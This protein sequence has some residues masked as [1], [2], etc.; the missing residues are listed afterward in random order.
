MSLYEH[1]E[2][3]EI[4]KS[5]AEA[6]GFFG[7][8]LFFLYKFV[9]GYL[10]TNLSLSLHCG[11]QRQNDR[12]DDLVIR[13]KL[14]KGDRGA[15]SLHDAQ[16]RVTFDGTSNTYVFRGLK[17]LSR[18]KETKPRRKIVGWARRSIDWENGAETSPFLKMT[19]GEETELSLGCAVPADKVCNVEVVILGKR[20]TST[21]F[22]QWRASCISLPVSS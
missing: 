5:Y 8:A 13:V 9:S 10:I 20:P 3:A 17:R 7:G 18:K 1:K 11:R 6:A 19:P 4:I 16:A 12:F 14:T 21:K 15:L 2:L 22:G